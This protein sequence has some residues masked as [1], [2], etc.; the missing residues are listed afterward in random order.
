MP[1]AD[2]YNFFALIEGMESTFF[3][4]IRNREGKYRYISPSQHSILGY[5]EKEFAE[6]FNAFLKDAEA[7]AGGVGK[8]GKVDA[9]KLSYE[10]ELAHKN[11]S[12][13]SLK[14]YEYPSYDAEGEI[15]ALQGLA[16]DITPRRELEASL[17]R[18]ET[19]FKQVQQMAQIGS[20]FLDIRANRLQWSE[21]VYRIF[22]RDHEDFE[23]SYEAFL[24]NIHPDDFESVNNAY[25]RSLEE[26]SPYS[27][28]HRL[29]MPD[30]RIKY[31]HEECET[32]FDERGEP[33]SSFGTVQDITVMKE[34][35]IEHE[36]NQEL[37]FQQSKMAQMGEMINSIAHQWKQPLHQINSVLPAIEEDFGSGTLSS[38]SLAA[39]LDE[40]E[41][42]TGHMSQTIESF[43]NFFHP[44]KHKTVFS[45]ADALAK[46][47]TLFGSE[48]ERVKIRRELSTHSDF[49]IGGSEK[50]FVQAIL[51]I[52]Q[53]SKEC[54]IHRNIHEPKIMIRI[55]TIDNRG[56]VTLTDNAGGIPDEYADKIFDPYFT[57]KR[58]GHG[59][60]LGLYIAKKLI[61]TALCGTLSVKN[62]IEGAEFIIALPLKG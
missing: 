62:G 33:I 39:K 29:L 38:A 58:K 57:T 16:E 13:R 43:Q 23:A 54:F 4:Y 36:I 31:V 15:I 34:L 32:F 25:I 10:G 37:M 50:E 61:E 5:R 18:N 26:K 12:Q 44:N 27:S 40:I 11:G 2:S 17:R 53:N 51:S 52:V 45:A 8:R 30:G 42:L 22:E 46:V 6:V 3:F 19:F 47:F 24:T 20:W 48:F 7:V 28:E 1:D 56:I 60:G 21:Q 41:M 35:Q 9:T 49:L 14:I 55:D 59:T